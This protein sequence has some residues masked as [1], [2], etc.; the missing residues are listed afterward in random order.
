MKAGEKGGLLSRKEKERKGRQGE[1]AGGKER[2]YLP[3]KLEA[4]SPGLDSLT[5]WRVARAPH[6]VTELIGTRKRVSRAWS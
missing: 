6:R 4:G 2:V 1:K 5:L 3:G